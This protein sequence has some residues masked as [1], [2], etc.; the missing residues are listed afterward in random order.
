[1]SRDRRSDNAA[2]GRREFVKLAGAAVLAGS[3][4]SVL[5]ARS[6]A[7]VQQPSEAVASP[8]PNSLNTSDILS[9]ALVAWGV[10]HVF[11]IV[12]DGINP[13]V[14]ALRKRRDRVLFVGVRHEEAAAFMAGGFAKHSGSLGV[15]LATTGPGAIHLMNGL[16]D[17]ALDGASVLAITGTTFHDLEGMRF[18]RA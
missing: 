18:M 1:M 11:G 13:I 12:G 7:S 9:E 4:T 6:E 17:A 2:L 10:T 3:A 15:C 14:E 5:A 16:Y 8:I